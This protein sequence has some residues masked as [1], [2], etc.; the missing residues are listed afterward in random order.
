ML[1][2]IGRLLG[3]KSEQKLEQCYA[4]LKQ[5]CDNRTVTNRVQSQIGSLFN[6][7]KVGN[8]LAF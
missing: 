3:V 5:L 4:H 2:T 1:K 6:L 8:K 7:R